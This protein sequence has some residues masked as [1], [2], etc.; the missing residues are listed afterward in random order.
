MAKIVSYIAIKQ[1]VTERRAAE[2]AQR[3]LAA[4][5]ESSEDAII[6]S[7]PAGI[8]LT[9]NRGAEAVFGYTAEE[10]IGKH[11]SMLVAPERLPELAYF[12][13]QVS[14]GITVSQ[15]ESLCLRKDGRGVSRVRHR[16][17]HSE[18]RR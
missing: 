16:V 6:A 15:Y 3:F 11:V 7:T 4:I 13:E 12:T 5:V 2:E 18:L 1:D 9:W 14:Q 17:T 8:I 10:A